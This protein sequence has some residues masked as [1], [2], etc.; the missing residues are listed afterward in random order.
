MNDS[1]LG[2]VA[3][4]SPDPAPLRLE[5]RYEEPGVTGAF[6]SPPG[7]MYPLDVEWV[8]STVGSG[9]SPKSNTTRS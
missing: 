7:V 1:T 6:G 2:F 9:P 5:N 4:E 8:A 3:A